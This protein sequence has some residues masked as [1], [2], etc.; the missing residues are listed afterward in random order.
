MLNFWQQFC[1]SVNIPDPGPDAIPILESIPKVMNR[2]W[3][4]NRYEAIRTRS[5]VRPVF[6]RGQLLAET[7]SARPIFYDN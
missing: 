2:H 4:G 1:R 3:K 5:P 6:S 7:K